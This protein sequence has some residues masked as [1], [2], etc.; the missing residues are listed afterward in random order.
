MILTGKRWGLIASAS[1]AARLTMR[2]AIAATYI[3]L[4]L[5]NFLPTAFGG[6]VARVLTAKR[7]GDR[8][9]LALSSVVLDR[10]LG[11]M[12]LAFLLVVV[13]ASLAVA[14]QARPLLPAAAVFAAGFGLLLASLWTG[15]HLPLRRSWLRSSAVIRFLA[16]ATDILR[17][18]SARPAM[19]AQVAVASVTA[20]ILGVAAYWGAVRC[21]SAD[22]GFAAALAAAALGTLASALPVSISGWG[23]RE[24]AVAVA[25]SGSGALSASD[26]SFVAILNGLVIAVTSLA[27]FAVSLAA[28]WQRRAVAR[29]GA[30]G[31]PGSDRSQE[32]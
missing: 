15:A 12:T 13:E 27:G 26:A 28:D 6:D 17:T 4:W 25:L 2:T 3:S 19:S 29:D 7:A 20:T 9:P 8:L 5:S 30:P 10:C 16:R 18:L 24:G 31:R 1:G 23:V 11:L 32:A 14:G 21:V 22:A